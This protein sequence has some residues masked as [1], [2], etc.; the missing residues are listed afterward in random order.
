MRLP[1]WTRHVDVQTTL[2]VVLASTLAAIAMSAVVLGIL[3]HYRLNRQVSDVRKITAENTRI[4]KENRRLIRAV[5]GNTERIFDLRR[6]QIDALK[7]SQRAA[8]RRANRSD[9]ILAR[10][11]R[12]A[13]ALLQDRRYGTLTSDQRAELV[14]QYRRALVELRPRRCDRLVVPGGTVSLSPGPSPRPPPSVPMPSPSSPPARRQPPRPAPS[15]PRS[16]PPSPPAAPGPP[17][18][19]PPPPP[20]PNP[21]PPP[22]IPLDLV[23]R[24]RDVICQLVPPACRR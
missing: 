9:A 20:P 6:L 16:P 21:P 12:A 23:D 15:P 24:I 13:L 8:C 22:P 3:T 11:V 18:P 14:R 5:D 17:P 1:R 7:A 10:L 2:I 19:R 4:A